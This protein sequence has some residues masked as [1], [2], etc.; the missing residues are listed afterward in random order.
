MR[1]GFLCLLAL[2]M[3]PPAHAQT[4]GI[5]IAEAADGGY[6]HCHGDSADGTLNCARRTCRAEGG[7][8]CLR[9]RWCYPAGHSGS[10]TYLVNR[11][12][13]R[14]A[15]L[16]GAPSLAALQRMLAGQ[17]AADK[18]VTECRLMVHWG[19]DGSEASRSDRLGKNTAD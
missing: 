4:K 13:T 19:P 1:L 17:C 5:A 10:M 2:L 15:F 16:C 12:V 8:N 9:V 7:E 3:V 11:E 14:T 18:A 6:Y